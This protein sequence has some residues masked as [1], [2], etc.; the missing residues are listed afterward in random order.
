MHILVAD[1][2]ALI[3]ELLSSACAR[4]GHQVGMATS[5]A[6]ALDYVAAC[7]VDLLIADV[8]MPGFAPAALLRAVQRR[9]PGLPVIAMLA[10]DEPL[11]VADLFG[12][13]AVDVLR[14]PFS[15]DDLAIRI[16]LVEERLRYVRDLGEETAARARDEA[17]AALGA[18]ART[19][20]GRAGLVWLDRFRDVRRGAA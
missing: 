11:L 7:P 4:G 6:A 5:A 19:A 10:H 2:E 17:L 18:P 1:D 16:G 12:E 9:R 15:M 8:E 13:G 3:A 20:R 14:K